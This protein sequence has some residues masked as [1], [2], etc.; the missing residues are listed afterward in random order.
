MEQ[1]INIDGEYFM[2]DFVGSIV[3]T[4]WDELPQDMYL[5]L[6]LSYPDDGVVR[7][8]A[9]E[10]IKRGD[11]F[12]RRIGV[13]QVMMFL[14]HEYPIEFFMYLVNMGVLNKSFARQMYMCHRYSDSD[15][16]KFINYC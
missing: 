15:I 2:E 1:H 16:I 14:R 10:S 7:A 5:E 3:E 11:L 4:Y 6:F 12:W 9:L 8:K 13:L